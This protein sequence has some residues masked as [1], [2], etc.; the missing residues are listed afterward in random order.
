M[1][2]TYDNPTIGIV[3]P[4]ILSDCVEVGQNM[5][6]QDAMEMWNYDRSLPEQACVNSFKKSIISMTIEHDNKPVA[7][8]GIMPKNFSTGIIWILTTNGLKDIGISFLS[9]C[10]RFI[11]EMLEIYPNLEGCVDL[12][13]TTSIRWLS[14]A[15][16]VW[17]DTET[18][19]IDNMPFRNFT[20][21]KQDVSRETK[22][23]EIDNLEA[24]IKQVPSHGEGDCLPLKHKFAE[25]MYVREISI[26]KGMLLIGKIHRKSNPVFVMKGDISI[27]SEEG[28]KRFKGGDY[29]ISQPGA[30]RVG[31]AHE[32]TTWVEVFATNET[33]LEKLEVEL[34]AKNYA[35]LAHNE[36]KF[37]DE[38]T[39]CLG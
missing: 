35:E 4:S 16:A 29:L 28:S 34:I 26:P 17:G 3:R 14:Y 1:I 36:K 5:R 19:G 8:F 37:I 7:M 18:M 38:V 32:D 25:G 24:K 13:N 33:N 11:S 21:S 9:N 22:R 39:K 6:E 23:Q 20:F 27:F 10:K 2:L 30:K 12:K 31:Y 15:G